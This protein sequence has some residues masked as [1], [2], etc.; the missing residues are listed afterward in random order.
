MS[1]R[2]SVLHPLVIAR[3]DTCEQRRELCRSCA[4]APICTLF[5]LTPL[6]RIRP[7]LP[8]AVCET[9][10]YLCA[11]IHYSERRKLDGAATQRRDRPLAN[12][13]TDV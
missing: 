2:P 1:R 4:P 8:R 6:R 7:A 11:R 12:A 9:E 10:G 5:I 13:L 3:N